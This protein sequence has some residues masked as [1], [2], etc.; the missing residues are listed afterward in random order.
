MGGQAVAELY[1]RVPCVENDAFDK[2]AEKPIAEKG[3]VS[4]IP[5]A[6]GGAGLDLDR[7][8]PSPGLDDEIDLSPACVAVVGRVD[9][10]GRPGR[11]TQD[12]VDGERFDQA[13]G[14]LA[15]QVAEERALVRCEQV[16]EE[17]GVRKRIIMTCKNRLRRSRLP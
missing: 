5:L 10:G 15:G 16:G 4:C 17:A 13:T 2:A 7:D 6:D 3:E 14:Q 11:L 8:D 9:C 12:L 1:R